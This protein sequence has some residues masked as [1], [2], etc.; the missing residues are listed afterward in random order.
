LFPFQ[1]QNQSSSIAITQL[2]TPYSDTIKK[3]NDNYLDG[4]QDIFSFSFPGNS[5]RFVFNKNKVVVPLEHTNCIVTPV[6][7]S[8]GYIIA[9]N[10]TDDKGI[11]YKFEYQEYQHSVAWNDSPSP[12]ANN[13]QNYITGW[14]LTQIIDPMTN[15]AIVIN[16]ADN[17]TGTSPVQFESGFSE[18][19]SYEMESADVSNGSTIPGVRLTSDVNAYTILSSNDPQV[20]YITFP[21]GSRVD[22]T[23]GFNRA[24]YINAKALTAF[25]VKNMQNV[26]VKTFQLNYSYFTA[27]SG[28][29]PLGMPSGNDF[30]KRL[31]LDGVN[32]VSNDGSIIKPTTFTY[33]SLPLNPRGSK[34]MD[35]WG[36]NVAPARNNPYYVPWIELAGQEVAINPTYGRYLTGADRSPDADYV[37]AAVLEKIQYPTGGFTTF[38]Y[39]CNKAFSAVNYYENSSNISNGWD[40]SG[41][42]QPISLDM[43]G[44]TA[45]GVKLVLAVQE[46]STRPTPNPNDPQS[47]LDTQQDGQTV[48]FVIT[49]T[50]NTFSSTV[51]DVYSSFNGAGKT[52][53]IDLPVDKIYNITF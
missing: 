7:N 34:N 36:Y 35:Y 6:Y 41:F 18:N 10:I 40:L 37:K 48:T 16:Y 30:T 17:A 22:F 31:R 33:N 4:E 19:Q 52:V 32:E 24:D 44:R 12:G 14:L 51:Q 38:S 11:L 28:Y 27:A 20:T 1:Q 13:T 23:Y 53:N 45:I 50:D 29:Y 3:I 15:D 8:S 25:T 46:F 49:S 9:F 5:C 42:N 39:E 21:D 43:P 26:V 47:C 2:N